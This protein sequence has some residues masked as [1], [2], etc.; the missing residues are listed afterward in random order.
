[1][2]VKVREGFQYRQ[3]DEKG[4]VKSH[5]EGEI[6]DLNLAKGETLHHALEK[7]EKV[8]PK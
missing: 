3:T 6:L 7:V 4:N 1:M 8:A 5:F 2:Q